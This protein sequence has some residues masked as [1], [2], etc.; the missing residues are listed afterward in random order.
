MMLVLNFT[1]LILFLA[2]RYFQNV[3]I[4]DR[5]DVRNKILILTAKTA[6]SDKQGSMKYSERLKFACK[7]V[8][9]NHKARV[10]S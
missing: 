4:E 3:D 5:V 1:E 6:A 2:A 7:R 10:S 9:T 8:Q